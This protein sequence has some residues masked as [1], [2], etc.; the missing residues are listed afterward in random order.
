MTLSDTF[1]FKA[2][3]SL[4]RVMSEIVYDWMIIFCVIFC[5][6]FPFLK[7]DKKEPPYFSRW[8]FSL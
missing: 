7:N 1:I 5:A 4:L 8:L 6:A 2:N 3:N